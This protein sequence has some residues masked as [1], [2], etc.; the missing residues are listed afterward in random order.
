MLNSNSFNIISF[1]IRSV[2]SI[3]KFDQFKELIARLPKLPDVI[4]LQETW[5]NKDITQIYEIP[6]FTNVHCCREDGY[7][8]TS[9]L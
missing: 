5:F 3:G 7:G 8:G 4:A 1:N 2:S 9:L 6:G